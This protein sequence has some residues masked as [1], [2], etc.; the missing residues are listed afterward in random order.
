M[1]VVLVFPAEGIFWNEMD[2]CR[3]GAMSYVVVGGYGRESRPTETDGVKGE[4]NAWA[5]T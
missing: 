3:V 4:A 5:K 1:L 2:V